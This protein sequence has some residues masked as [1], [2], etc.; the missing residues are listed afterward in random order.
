MGSEG[1]TFSRTP[2][3]PS[4]SIATTM[5]AATTSALSTFDGTIVD[6]CARDWPSIV[7]IKSFQRVFTYDLR[8]SS[9]LFAPC[10]RRCD[11]VATPDV[12]LVHG[13]L[14]AIGRS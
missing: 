10:P 13:S 8:L 4:P 1:E 9:A 7:M 3:A 12:D 6:S 5:K 11:Q 2:I 14:T